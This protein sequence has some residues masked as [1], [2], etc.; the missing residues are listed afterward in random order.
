MQ[1]AVPEKLEN[2]NIVVYGKSQGYLGLP[3][4]H[5]CV[6]DETNGQPTMSITTAWLPTPE[7]LAALNAGAVILVEQL[8]MTRPYPMVLSVGE[9]AEAVEVPEGL[10]I[11]RIPGL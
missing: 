10:E 6:I 8:H 5:A 11:P 2:T 1:I 3:V 4:R 7:E 9:P